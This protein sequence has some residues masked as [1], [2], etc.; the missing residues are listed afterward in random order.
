MV[1][2]DLSSILPECGARVSSPMQLG[3]RIF[4]VPMIFFKAGSALHFSRHTFPA[5]SCSG[6]KVLSYFGT[7]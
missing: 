5:L 2:D 6:V 4:A 7:C 1:L 3:K